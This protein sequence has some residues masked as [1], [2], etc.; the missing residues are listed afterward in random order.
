MKGAIPAKIYRFHWLFSMHTTM[1]NNKKALAP[2]FLRI[3]I[4]ETQFF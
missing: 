1:L 4:P 2:K 3:I